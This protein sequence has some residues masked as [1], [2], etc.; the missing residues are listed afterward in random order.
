MDK[1][2]YFIALALFVSFPLVGVYVHWLAVS[3]YVGEKTSSLWL[4]TVL[5]FSFATL[6][7]YYGDL[8]LLR[9]AIAPILR[10][11]WT[12]P[13]GVIFSE[14]AF[15]L[16]IPGTLISLLELVLLKLASVAKILPIGQGRLSTLAML[17][18][19]NVLLSIPLGFYW[20]W[21]FARDIVSVA[22]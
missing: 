8:F 11:G 12:L 6:V 19:A 3:K 17:F 5:L 21:R 18:L 4:F 14:F 13:V 20:L 1:V 22:Q 9:L 7:I 2:K 10:Q 15:L 16:I